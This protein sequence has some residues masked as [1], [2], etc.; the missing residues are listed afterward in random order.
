MVA[1]PPLFPGY[2]HRFERRM[3]LCAEEH[4]IPLHPLVAMNP[5]I[6]KINK[7]IEKPE[8]CKF[9][10]GDTVKVYIKVVEGDKE[11]EQIFGGVV[12]RQAGGKGLPGSFTVRRISYGEGVE[13]VFPMHSPRV[14]WVEVVKR[15]APRRAR[16]HYLRGREGKAAMFVK[17]PKPNTYH[18]LREIS[19][20]PPKK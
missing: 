8:L 4:P 7:T 16:L 11:R 19:G 14:T 12:I 20:P 6:A 15:G 18:A 17:E 5:I 10:V 13:R 3:D 1:S 2:V 9:A